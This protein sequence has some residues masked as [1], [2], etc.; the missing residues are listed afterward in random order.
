[1]DDLPLQPIVIIVFLIIGAIRWFIENAIKGKKQPPPPEH[2]E[3]YDNEERADTINPRHG[4]LED[5]YEE[6]RREI[7][8][9]QNRNTPEPATV[10][11]QLQDYHTPSAPPPLPETQ[12]TPSPPTQP[13]KKEPQLRSVQRAR[14]TKEEEQAIAN[15]QKLGQKPNHKRASSFKIQELL[16]SPTAAR[17]AIVLSEILGK[18]KS[19]QSEAQ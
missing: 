2:W 6:A 3:E 7:L 9:R 13:S 1:M 19:L 8:D 10:Q 12:H 16:S 11:E 5:L 15:F 14:L 17:D 18:P 4:S